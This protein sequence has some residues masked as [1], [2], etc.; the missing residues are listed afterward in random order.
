MTRPFVHSFSIWFTAAGAAVKIAL[1]PARA[2][3]LRPAERWPAPPDDDSPFGLN[4]HCFRPS[5]A[6]Q[7]KHR[8]SREVDSNIHR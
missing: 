1:G 8:V 2:L 4:T 3:V 5:D 6:I 7:P